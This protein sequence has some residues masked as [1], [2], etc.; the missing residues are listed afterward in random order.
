MSFASSLVFAVAVWLFWFAL[1]RP[2]GYPTHPFVLWL[3]LMGTVNYSV[4]PSYLSLLK[5]RHVIRSL[6]ASRSTKRVVL[7]LVVDLVSTVLIV[8][9]Y[10]WF[11]MWVFIPQAQE[12]LLNDL[13]APWNVLRRLPFAIF[14]Q[15]IV[16]EGR[17]VWVPVGVFLYSAFFSSV[18]VWIGAISSLLVKGGQ[19]LGLRVGRLRMVFNISNKPFSSIGYAGMVITTALFLVGLPFATWLAGRPEPAR[20]EYSILE[21]EAAP[22]IVGAGV[23]GRIANEDGW[24]EPYEPF[25][26]NSDDSAAIA[27][28]V[29]ILDT[30]MVRT[31]YVCIENRSKETSDSLDVVLRM[32]GWLVGLHVY[33]PLAGDVRER[34]PGERKGFSGWQWRDSGLKSGGSL[35]IRVLWFPPLDSL[36][37][38]PKARAILQWPRGEREKAKPICVDGSPV[39]FATPVPALAPF[40]ARTVA[41]PRVVSITEG[42]GRGGRPTRVSSSAFRC[43]LPCEDCR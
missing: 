25:Q 37:E 26:F 40:Q 1:F 4:L 10:L 22:A 41:Y 27:A 13:Y 36:K 42:T 34:A 8:T 11:F 6:S 15:G 3:L 19:Y 17:R 24:W 5:T 35:L 20:L 23:L 28:A 18:W 7:L 43:P 31:W 12:H 9:G 39:C 16:D 30:L 21:R 38:F 33:D 2:Q 32:P 14:H 29:A